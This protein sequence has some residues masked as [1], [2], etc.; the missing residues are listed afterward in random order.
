MDFASPPPSQE[1]RGLAPSAG[2]AAA[3]AAAA[4]AQRERLSGA[5]ARRQLVRE[6]VQGPSV[7]SSASRGSSPA[8]REVREGGVGGVQLHED[9]LQEESDKQVRVQIRRRLR[10]GIQ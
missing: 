7:S 9:D 2:A 3:A 1:L 5:R 8:V 4:A 10:R 6:L